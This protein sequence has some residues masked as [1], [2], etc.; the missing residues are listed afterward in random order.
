MRLTPGTRVGVFEIVGP[1]GAGGMGEVYRARDATLGRDVALK[2]LPDSFARDPERLTRFRREARL[3]ASL[4]HP[5]I[6][7]IYGFEEAGG[8][9]ALVLELVEGLTLAERIGGQPIAI[10][11]ALPIARQ[12]AEALDTAHEAGVVHRD[13]KP[14]NIKVRPDGTVKILDFGLAKALTD[15]VAS[16]DLT[17]A[18]TITSAATEDGVVLG[19]PA[20]M[21]PEQARG[22]AADK[23]AD[24]WAFGCVLYEMISGRRAFDARTVSD[25]IVA[26]LTGEPD[27][28]AL[29][30]ETPPG[31]RRLLRRC[32]ERDPKRRLRD[33]G[34]ALP[35][36]AAADA[37]PPDVA[38]SR[39]P[40]AS[41]GVLRWAPWFLTAAAAAAAIT[42]AIR[43]RDGTAVTDGLALPALEQLTYDGGLTTMPALSPDGNLLAYA[44]DRGGHGDLDIWVQRIGGGAPLRLTDDPADD[45][46][47]DFS[48]D[49]SQIVFRSERA[50]G[51]VY[52]VPA[53]GGPARRIVQ[54]GRD[55][56][57]APDGKRIA[58]WSGAWRGHAIALRSSVF[59][60][61]LDGGEPTRIVPDFRMARIPAWSPDG[62]SLLIQGRRDD[63]I[64]SFDWWRIPLDGGTPVQTGIFALA[65]RPDSTFSSHV[66]TPSGV[67]LSA[68]GYNL[69][70]VALSSDGR[71]AEP[72]R[73]LTAVTGDAFHPS[74]SRDGS[75][76]FAA[77]NRQ[78]VIVRAPLSDGA[79]DQLPLLIYAD[80][81]PDAARASASA[82]GSRLVFEQWF[83]SHREVWQRDLRRDQQEMVV[84]VDDT[85][86]LNPTVSPDGARIAYTT[87]V[88]GQPGTGFVI[89]ASGGT[90]RRVCDKCNLYGFL[91]DN[92]RVLALRRGLIAAIDTRDGSQIELVRTDKGSLDRP[93]VSPDDRWIAFRQALDTGG[94]TFLAAVSPGGAVDPA[95]WQ[96]I[97]E[98]TTS[99]RPA[100]W[101]LDARVLYLLLDTD[102]FRCLWG[103]R[104]DAATGR[105][106]GVPVA[107]RHFHDINEA[108]STSF[109]NPIVPD[110][111]IFETV[112]RTGN[113]WRLTVAGK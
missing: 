52:V 87:H 105:L 5:H 29:P 4:N 27:W 68:G 109:G 30:A 8:V 69:W 12:I 74:V 45:Q 33:I 108:A 42:I 20:Y 57:F 38:P 77:V 73:A 53:L 9:P 75:V 14:G 13:L 78:R 55:P 1:L 34:D 22:Q 3:L 71:A 19:T 44:S 93:H 26:V 62:Q 64:D 15:A 28:S 31:I 37:T 36:L 39:T 7:S 100:G 40:S 6:G 32:L 25:T 35:D 11:D 97:D 88:D 84:R 82:D 90:P 70:S 66:W 96:Q 18:P 58:Y 113:L 16:G 86:Q 91:S 61:S 111:F 98:P 99:G 110:G 46:M 106:S 59:V 81:R 47:P 23:R 76:V 112:K 92:R 103:Q 80:D 10:A 2:V 83:P 63:A 21:S 48:P 102:G 95:A 94:K 56:K 79:H 101:S 85:A 50:G 72:M 17:L 107:V 49:G 24:I 54:D 67:I 65:G 51:G 60:A 89:D 41:R 104:V 43:N